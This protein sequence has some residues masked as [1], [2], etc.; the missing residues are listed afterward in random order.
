MER[1][2]IHHDKT[3]KILPLRYASVR[4]TKSQLALFSCPI[5]YQ[6]AF[7][8]YTRPYRVKIKTVNG[9]V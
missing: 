7:F 6:V 2:M 3:F 9:T 1:S 4:M 8:P 5:K